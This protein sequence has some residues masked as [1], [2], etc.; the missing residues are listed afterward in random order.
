MQLYI[1]GLRVS[2]HCV[3]VSIK[4]GVIGYGKG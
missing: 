4:A 1:L 3:L 2:K